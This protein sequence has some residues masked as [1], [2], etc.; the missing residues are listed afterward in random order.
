M[1]FVLPYSTVN[2]RPACFSSRAITTVVRSITRTPANGPAIIR[3]RSGMT[4]VRAA[5][6]GL[7]A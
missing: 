4:R 1:S 3:F 5:G 2:V 6:A 7:R